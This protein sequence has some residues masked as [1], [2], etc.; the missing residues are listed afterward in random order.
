MLSKQD[1]LNLPI[2]T[3]VIN[4]FKDRIR[5]KQTQEGD[6]I[7]CNFEN[8]YRAAYIP[9]DRHS[10]HEQKG[11]TLYLQENPQIEK[12]LDIIETTFPDAIIIRLNTTKLIKR[13]LTMKFK[14]R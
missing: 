4:Q 11:Q 7:G 13:T 9:A 10:F 1:C 5:I 8:G 14:G 12:W 2:G 3:V 6:F